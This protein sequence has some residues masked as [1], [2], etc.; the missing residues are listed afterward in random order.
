MVPRPSFVGAQHA[1]PWASHL[2][3]LKDKDWNRNTNIRIQR[4][5]QVYRL[6]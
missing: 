3:L 1:A 6:M 5:G 4:R 2:S